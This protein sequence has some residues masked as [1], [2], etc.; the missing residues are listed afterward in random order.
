MAFRDSFE[1]PSGGGGVTDH[2]ALTGLSDDDHPQ[3]HTDARGDARYLGKTAKAADADLLDGLDSTAFVKT[4]DHTKA[5]HDALKID[6]ATVSDFGL[7]VA[8]AETSGTDISLLRGTGFYRHNR[9]ATGSAGGPAVGTGEHSF[10]YLIHMEHSPLWSQQIAMDFNNVATYQRTSTD[11]GGVRAWKAWKRVVDKDYG[12]ALY[13]ALGHVGSRNGHPLATT[14]LDGF[15]AGADK[16]TISSLRPNNAYIQLSRTADQSVADSTWTPINW[17]DEIADPRNWHDNAV[18]LMRIVADS[19]GFY[20]GNA[21]MAWTVNSTGRRNIRV[22]KNGVTP[23]SQ[24]F[25]SAAVAPNCPVPA[26]FEAYLL[27]GE[28]LQAEVWQNSGGAL[29]LNLTSTFGMSRAL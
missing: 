14:T 4:V 9:S 20:T 2:G 16:A 1:E 21:Y 19:D 8:V 12:D 29:A 10:I 26:P 15:M 25:G 22:M 24:A 27:A 7:G 18:N 6:A 13:A 17:N 28:Y 23:I 3:Y 11:V 5:A